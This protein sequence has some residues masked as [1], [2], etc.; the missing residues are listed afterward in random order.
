MREPAKSEAVEDILV[1]TGKES[2]T[3]RPGDP[4]PV[5]DLPK[6]D[7]ANQ[8]AQ[9]SETAEFG[10]PT[11]PAPPAPAP[12]WTYNYVTASEKIIPEL[13]PEQEKQVQ[14]AMKASQKVMAEDHWKLMEKSIADAMTSVEKENLKAEYNAQMTKMDWEKLEDQLKLAY[15]KINWNQVNSQLNSAMA[16]IKLDSLQ[17]VYSVAVA[18]LANLEKE[19]KENKQAGIP[20]TDITLKTLS[21]QRQQAQKLINTIKAARNRKIVHL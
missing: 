8:A 17:K 10:L 19:L 12:A 4:K 15:E 21:Q 9:Q 13:E 2:I 11:P 7:L 14:E 1:E 20:D 18:E 6:A 5:A 16:E 3:N